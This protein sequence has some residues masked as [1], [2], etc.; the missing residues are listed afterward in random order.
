[1]QSEDNGKQHNP[2][3]GRRRRRVF[4]VTFTDEERR[5][6]AQAAS[7]NHAPDSTW[8]RSLLL[9]A[10]DRILKEAA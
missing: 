2:T 5:R 7:A 10:A 4:T 1:M 6:I 8:A 9:T 3:G